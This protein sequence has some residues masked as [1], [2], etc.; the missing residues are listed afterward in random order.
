M[1]SDIVVH[2]PMTDIVASDSFFRFYF[3][4]ATS[5]LFFVCRG[6]CLFVFTRECHI[7]PFWIRVLGDGYSTF[8]LLW[9]HVE[10]RAWWNVCERHRVTTDG[11]E[12]R[13]GR[14]AQ[15]GTRHRFWTVM[16]NVWA[17]S[18]HGECITGRS[19]W[20]GWPN[21]GL[22]NGAFTSLSAW[23]SVV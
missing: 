4:L 11:P 5:N 17:N 12:P 21:C 9:A 7:S 20:S 19:S 14:L 22:W 10:E 3:I 16:V 1:L 2:E 8:G 15:P 13:L 23:H 18:V 6:L